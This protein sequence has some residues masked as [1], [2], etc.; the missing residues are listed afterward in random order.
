MIKVHE[1]WEK[2][3]LKN[4]L[5][6]C[7][8]EKMIGPS[9]L[10]PG[11]NDL[12]CDLLENI[13]KQSRPIDS[14][15]VNLEDELDFLPDIPVFTVT[16]ENK[17][18]Y[19]PHA[20]TLPNGAKV[21][22]RACVSAHNCVGK[23][24]NIV[25]SDNNGGRVLR[26]MLTPE[27]LVKFETN[28]VLPEEPRL[29]VLCARRCATVAYFWCLHERPEIMLRNTVINAYVNP[30]DCENGYLSEYA[31]PNVKDGSW[32]CMV[33]PIVTNSHSKMKYCK[34]RDGI[35][36][37]NQEALVWD[38]QKVEDEDMSLF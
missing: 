26:K 6:I 29:C 24:P 36:Y 10:L 27:E 4:S 34:N 17:M 20:I 11:S 25:N 22:M 21:N 31:I 5:Q 19:E 37:V 8:Q 1:E 28:G 35:W 23:D 32:R 9:T 15:R 38:K 33:G 7:D 18:L 16:H 3:M 12:C 30:V 13:C 2:I 14:K